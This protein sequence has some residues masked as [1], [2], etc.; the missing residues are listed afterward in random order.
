MYWDNPIFQAHDIA[1]IVL[2]I[3]LMCAAYLA[4]ILNI[5]E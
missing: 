3:I 4:H 1:L 2:F 5:A